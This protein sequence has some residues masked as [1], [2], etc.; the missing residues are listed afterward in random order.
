MVQRAE[1]TLTG[2]DA[3]WLTEH[4]ERL[5]CPAMADLDWFPFWLRDFDEGTRE[6]TN[7]EVGA[8]LRLLYYQF[9]S[10]SIPADRERAAHVTGERFSDGTW[11]LLQKKFVADP[12]VPADR[13]VN[14]RMREVRLDAEARFKRRSEANRQNGRAGGLARGERLQSLGSQQPERVASDSPAN[15]K[16]SANDTPANERRLSSTR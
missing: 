13:L 12:S 11:Q 14:L 10:G 8:Y 4:A 6:M 7:E 1:Y 16:R 9:H 5:S 15:G 3:R 2:R